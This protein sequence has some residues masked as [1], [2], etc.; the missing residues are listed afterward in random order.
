M[1]RSTS[2]L[3][4]ILAGCTGVSNLGPADSRARLVRATRGGQVLLRQTHGQV[5]AELSQ[6]WAHF[7]HDEWHR[8]IDYLQRFE[9][10]LARSPGSQR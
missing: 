4:L 1:T 6:V 7:T 2:L 8:F 3:A 5:T 10:A 9:D